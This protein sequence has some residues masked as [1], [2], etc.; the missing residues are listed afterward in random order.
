[1]ELSE[2]W[3]SKESLESLDVFAFN[4]LTTTKLCRIPFATTELRGKGTQCDVTN[5]FDG[6]KLGPSLRDKFEGKLRVFWK[7]KKCF[8]DFTSTFKAW[9]R[10]L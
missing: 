9:K 10:F 2:E 7:P 8:L 5:N 4:A 1:M 6:D 3:D